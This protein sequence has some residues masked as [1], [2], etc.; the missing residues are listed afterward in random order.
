M[1]KDSLLNEETRRNDMGKDITQA[2]IIE[3]RGGSKSRS[4]KRQ[5]KSKSQ[6]ESK[7]KIQV[8]LL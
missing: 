7:G 1:V 6:L 8:L 4:F 2:L 3:N 5:G